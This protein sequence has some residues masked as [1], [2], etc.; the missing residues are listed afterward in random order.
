[1]ATNNIKPFGTS[2][3]ANLLTDEELS[4]RSELQ[5]GFPYKSKADSKLVGKLVQNATAGA[6]AVGEFSAKYG[7]QNVSGSDATGFATAFE[8]ALESYINEKAPTP[9]LSNYVEKEANF[10]NELLYTGTSKIDNAGHIINLISDV[11]VGTG[12]SNSGTVLKPCL[13]VGRAETVTLGKAVWGGVTIYDKGSSGTSTDLV[14]NNNGGVYIKGSVF[15]NTSDE[16]YGYVPSN[17]SR[18][19]DIRYFATDHDLNKYLPLT[20]GT[21]TGNLTEKNSIEYNGDS[22]GT[23]VFINRDIDIDPQDGSGYT[24]SGSYS[25]SISAGSTFTPNKTGIVS[26]KTTITRTVAANALSGLTKEGSFENYITNDESG[27]RIRS[28]LQASGDEKYDHSVAGLSLQS[29]GK[30]DLSEDTS[31]YWDGKRGAVLYAEAHN[32]AAGEIGGGIAVVPEV[33]DENNSRIR[34][35][36]QDNVISPEG[37]YCYG[38]PLSDLAFAKATGGKYNFLGIYNDAPTQRADATPLQEG[39]LI[40]EVNS[41]GIEQQYSV[42]NGNEWVNITEDTDYTYTTKGYVD[43]IVASVY[44]YK[45]SVASESA[46]PS[47]DQT[48]GDVYNVEDTGDNYAWDGSQWDKLGGT[49]DLSSYLKV[50]T[51]ADTYLSKTDASSTYATKTEV[52]DGLGQKLAI[53][54]SRGS[55]AGYESITVGST[56]ITINQDSPDSQQVTS[57]VAITVSDGTS[58][59]SWVKKVSIKDA[60]VTISLGSAWVWA[61]G[62]QPTVTAPSL[63]VLSWDNDCGIAVLQTTA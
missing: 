46:L 16:E 60:G 44:K 31:G 62:S 47:S 54:G 53:Q 63:L 8:N 7:T 5:T 13:S 30:Y 10:S 52:T 18:P 33:V 49:V 28:V 48:V 51:A 11:T 27:T 21:I 58:D 17:A 12:F 6:Y 34:V 25:E 50:A 45:G 1:M 3:D 26:Q 37:D 2:V 40:K 56:A 20:G 24:D 22:S 32:E 59:Y 43:S 38:F 55:L 9:D 61:G 14:D 35:Y 57:A 39:D 41:S 29:Y 23:S 19:S 36:F 42:W 15:F 4:A